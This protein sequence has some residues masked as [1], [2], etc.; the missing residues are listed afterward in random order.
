MGTGVLDKF[1]RYIHVEYTRSERV[2]AT[3]SVNYEER[4]DKSFIQNYAMIVYP[5]IQNEQDHT[6]L[7]RA[8]TLVKFLR[9]WSSINPSRT[10]KVLVKEVQI[11]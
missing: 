2:I 8:K 4:H 9:N 11:L 6:H 3:I 10:L 5:V 1:P 7:A